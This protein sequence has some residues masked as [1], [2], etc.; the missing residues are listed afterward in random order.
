MSHENDPQASPLSRPN[1]RRYQGYTGYGYGGAPG[2]PGYGPGGGTEMG[3]QKTLLD[4][5]ILIRQRIWYL[6]F[7]FII[8]FGGVAYFTFTTTK[9]YT[10]GARVRILR[11]DVS[12]MTTQVRPD[13]NSRIANLEDFNTQIQIM[14]SNTIINAVDQRLRGEE[15][16]LFLRP[17]EGNKSQLE[18]PLFTQKIL[19]QGRTV[20]PQRASLIADIL[21]RHP[22]PEI[23]ASVANYFAEE[24]RKYNIN[25]NLDE[26]RK[27]VSDLKR[28]S[29]EQRKKV[30]ELELKAAEYKERFATVS[31]D[32]SENIAQQQL[33]QLNQILTQD[34]NTFNNL[35]TRLDQVR[36][37][38]EQ[39]LPLSDLSFIAQNQLVGDLL[40]TRST[41]QITIASLGE[42]YRG[43]HPRMIEAT[44]A[45]AEV[46]SELDRAIRSARAKLL[47]DYEQAQT[48]FLQSQRNIELQ[49]ANLIEVS[50]IRTDYNSILLDLDVEKSFYQTLTSEL[51]KREAE[52]SWQNA[53]VQ[54]IDRALPA[55]NPSAPKV[56]LNLAAG[57]VGG[58]ALGFGFVFMLAFFD[59]RIKTMSDVED[60]LGLSILGVIPKFMGKKAFKERAIA[61]ISQKHSHITES[62]RSL[63]SSLQIVEDSR[64]AKRLLITS[65]VPGEGKSTISTNLAQSFASH[66]CKTLLIDCDLRLPN[67]ARIL[68][69]R[70]EKGLLDHFSKNVPEE[71]LI[72]RGYAHNLDILPVYGESRNPIQIINSK[73]FEEL[74]AR[75]SEQY[76][77]IILD[78]PPIGA[79]S[80]ALNLLTL[81]DGVLYV[82]A[83]NTVKMRAA[84]GSIRRIAE[85][86]TPIFGSVLNSVPNQ[87]TSYY[88]S[89]YYYKAYEAGYGA[90]KRAARNRGA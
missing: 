22:N 67:I 28:K 39:R 50:K 10:S 57:F 85:T 17:F 32:D 66:G 31:V 12:P 81:A 84:Q 44:R 61:V 7:I 47:A 80:D 15:R 87:I 78:S 62:F 83:Y 77:K 53:N 75:L 11:T 35:Q 26:A 37:H 54:I 16:Q 48:N 79:V 82:I 56:A 68:E 19:F 24:Y 63:Y 34:R 86:Q 69:I 73:E 52:T 65:T 46:E 51:S 49:Q 8:V 70:G 33:L 55:E 43:K 2:Y 29:E 20:R 38:E 59:D 21:F 4:Y 71:S 89:H 45:L 30:R 14:E 3:P 5:I 60:T 6:I 74:L 58:I 25:L 18:G 64:T 76:D 72:V 13:E 88:Y 40:A 9:Q 36:Q 23:A 1:S 27:S 41:Q 42:R 90:S